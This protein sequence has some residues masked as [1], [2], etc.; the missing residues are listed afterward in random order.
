MLETTSTPSTGWTHGALIHIGSPLDV[1]CFKFVAQLLRL[2]QNPSTM[3]VE[4]LA[5]DINDPLKPYFR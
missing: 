2:L 1:I 4:N 5:I 3:R